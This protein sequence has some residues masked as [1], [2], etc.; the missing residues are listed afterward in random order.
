MAHVAVRVAFFLDGLAPQRD[1]GVHFAFDQLGLED[2]A[3]VAVFL[4]GDE[5]GAGLGGV[6]RGILG[7]DFAV[8]DGEVFAD[9]AFPSGEIFAVE[10]MLG[11][12]AR[13]EF[14]DL[15]FAPIRGGNRERKEDRP[16]QTDSE[17]NRRRGKRVDRR[18]RKPP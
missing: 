15:I 8:L 18:I 12:F 16:T 7:D 10:E 17:T 1:A 4:F 3:E 9:L 14:G 13:G 5:I 11:F 6:L 2:Q